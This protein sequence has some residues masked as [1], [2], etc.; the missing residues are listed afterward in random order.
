M[1]NQQD[2]SRSTLDL[3]PIARSYFEGGRAKL[4]A[5]L[6]LDIVLMSITGVGLLLILPLLGLLGFGS[7][8]VNNPIWQALISALDRVGLTL[9]LP[10]GL[11]LFIA[12]VSLRALLN[13]RRATWQVEVEQQF[14]ATLRIRLYQALSRTE[15]YR[16]E[17]LRTS[18]FIQSAQTESR[19]TQQAANVLFQL[20]SQGVNL[21]VYFTVALVLSWQITTFAIV[22]GL[23]GFIV[24]L[25]IVQRT[26]E[27][28]RK[29][30]HVRSSMVNNLIEHIQGLHTAR[31]LG[32][33]ARFVDEFKTRCMQ[34]A[35]FN[36]RLVRFSALSNLIFEVV[37]VALLAAIV[38]FGLS[39]LQIEATRFIV[40]LVIFIKIFPSMG[41]LQQL[42][43]RL[44]SLIPSFRHYLDLLDDLEQHEEISVE[45]ADGPRM[46]MRHSLELRN[47]SFNYRSSGR[48]ALQDVSLT[49]EKGT[50]SAIG[51]HSGAGKST[52]V[53]IA[54]GLLPAQQGEL[55]LDGTILGK[56]ERIL[57]RREIGMVPQDSFMFDD[58]I[59]ANLQCA[60]PGASEREL[61]DVLDAVKARA[62]VE[63]RRDGLDSTVGEQGRLLA[64]GER[65]RICIARALLR[66]PQLLVLDEPT[67]NLDEASEG[68]LLEFLQD[69]KD[70]AT[71]IVISHEKRILRCADR[72]FELE[73]GV[74]SRASEVALEPYE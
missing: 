68:A 11:M 66:D 55:L 2:L 13:W 8:D 27:L 25:P 10:V 7:G 22:C 28:S 51:G 71:L 15:L 5:V 4:F 58:T 61:W 60:K 56:Q 9:S 63:S 45:A 20:F 52:L 34:S 44:M 47:V 69:L 16:L 43:Q 36:V 21:G 73:E 74:L 38:Y 12:A 29:L 3:L 30:I 14:Q 40:L 53:D 46:I 6:V 65:Q 42:F 26:H 50:L 54:T 62:F 67:N 1:S 23:I 39:Y 48:P 72:V 64:G 41:T 32:L 33:T 57:W 31:S 35:N 59:R 24:M 70:K 18:E 19:R 17:Q 49:I 37:A